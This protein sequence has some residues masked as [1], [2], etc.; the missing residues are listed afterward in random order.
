MSEPPPAAGQ[1]RKLTIW[2]QNL[3]K[4]LDNQQ[5]LLESM[6]RDKYHF[7]ALQEPYMDQN[8]KTRANAW[9]TAVYPSEHDTSEERSRAVMLVNRSLASNAWSQI[10]IPCSDVVGIELRGDFGTLR[11]INIYNDGGHDE[12]L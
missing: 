10:Y 2:Q 8:R 9:W 3:D 4:G 12:S 1:P 11:V 7:A 5:I 6:G